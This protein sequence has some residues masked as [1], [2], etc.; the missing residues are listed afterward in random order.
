VVDAKLT[1]LGC[2]T[3]TG[4]PVPGCDCQ[5][6]LSPE[7]RNKRLRCSALITLN[8]HRNILID[9]SPDLRA[10][11]L[12][13]GL[14]RLDGVLFTHAH[15][16]HILGIDDLRVF[17]FR[18]KTKLP[19]FAS[20]ETKEAIQRTFHYLFCNRSDYEG[21]LLADLDLAEIE[22][23]IPL[24]V[25]GIQVTPI[26]VKHG[27]M[28]VLGFRLGDLAYVTDCNVISEESIAALV[29]V[30]TL[31]LDGLR[32]ENHRTHFTI[33]EAIEAAERIGAKQTYL[34]HMTHTVDY[35][36]TSARLP[37]N[38]ALCYDG[39]VLNFTPVFLT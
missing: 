30:K 38:V 5:V 1:I 10:Q 14:K 33:P 9:A 39:L 37:K 32:Y 12:A 22:A 13:F 11:A 20:R 23:F 34:T 3:S 18:S 15:A 2:G 17:N 6:C 27:K 31:I 29:G 26:P 25:A 19:C 35:S 7:P 21:G 4:V 36:E 28:D 24:S 16:D 8:D